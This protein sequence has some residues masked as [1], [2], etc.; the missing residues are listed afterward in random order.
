MGVLSG[1]DDITGWALLQK[2]SA[3]IEK[4]YAATSSSASDIAY[5]KKIA[6]TLTTPEKL[7]G[8]YR[9]LTFVTTA[10]GMS[11]K[12]DQTALL[13]KLMTQDPSS[14]S[15]LAQQLGTSS[16]LQFANA[17]SN[18]S[19]PPFSTQ[20]GI[21][22]AVSGYQQNAFDTEVGQDNTVLQNAL[23]F[24]Q[25]AKG[26]T[27]LYQLMADPTLLS[28]VTGAL[29]IPSAFGNLSFTQQVSMLKPL[30]DMKQF[31]TAAGVA[32]FVNKYIAMSEVNDANSGATGSSSSSPGS[33]V[34]SLFSSAVAT[35]NTLN[36]SGVGSTSSG[37]TLS[38]SMFGNG[39]NLNFL[40]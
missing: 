10:F 16:V 33:T 3:A 35:G 22:K 28:V 1:I 38:A 4:S 40:A 32:S 9:A 34:A 21:D 2:N 19:P 23:Y 15:S 24:S 8:N 17:L 12:Q 31:S 29:G 39:S 30:V 25:N 14:S 36:G 5:F 6:P 18:W 13:K 27:T 37:L 7:L 26:A 20:A 11:G